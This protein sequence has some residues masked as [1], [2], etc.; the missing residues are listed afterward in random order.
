ME[1]V[2]GHHSVGESN[3][4][5]QFT[6]KYRRDIFRDEVVKEVCEESFRET[7]DK[8]GLVIHSLAFGPDHVHVFVGACKNHSVA[9]TVRRLKGASS[10]R[11]R[12]ECGDRVKSKLWGKAFWS[13]GYFYR[14][15]GSTTDEAIQYYVERSQGKHW[16]ALDHEEYKQ[17][18]ETQT[19]ITQF[20]S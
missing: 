6:P 8:L 9:E 5:L 3:L 2:R 15:V 17:R 19:V 16:T 12:Q 18:K 11:I 20:A 7:A 13:G 14:S 4:H 1:M 10:R